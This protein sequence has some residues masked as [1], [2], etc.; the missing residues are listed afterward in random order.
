[1]RQ[2]YHDV[3]GQSQVETNF[4]LFLF[5]C[6][7]VSYSFSLLLVELLI[8]VGE[9]VDKLFDEDEELMK[10]WLSGLAVESDQHKDIQKD[11]TFA[12][13]EA[14][15]QLRLD[16]LINCICMCVYIYLPL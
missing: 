9:L 14:A 3:L 15:M 12:L 6:V 1:M 10:S 8:K 13:L 5:V 2:R 16:T 4:N 7:F 11:V